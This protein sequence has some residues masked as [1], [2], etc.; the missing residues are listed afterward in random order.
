MTHDLPCV[1]DLCRIRDRLR[2]ILT[3]E[4]GSNYR[5]ILADEGIADMPIERL[6]SNL[7]FELTCRRARW[8]QFCDQARSFA[9]RWRGAPVEVTRDCGCG[10]V[11]EVLA[12][13]ELLTKRWRQSV[14]WMRASTAQH[15][16][17]MCAEEL[18][19]VLQAKESQPSAARCAD[20]L[21][22]LIR[23]YQGTGA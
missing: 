16:A 3:E 8:A 11:L 14:W 12:K 7:E 10:P 17:S 21:E 5:D 2:A 4:L 13:V 15:T 9:D 22:A 6:L 1:C 20:E 23:G 19:A 18:D